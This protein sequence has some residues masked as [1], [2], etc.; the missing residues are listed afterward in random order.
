[1]PLL[2][3]RRRFQ[4]YSLSH[5]PKGVTHDEARLIRTRQRVED[6]RVAGVR[7]ALANGRVARRVRLTRGGRAA[8]W[9]GRRVGAGAYGSVYATVSRPEVMAALRGAMANRIE[10]GVPRAGVQVVIKV[11]E[12]TG[13]A[14]LQ[15][16]VRE[17]AVHHQLATAPCLTSRRFRKPVCVEGYVPRLYFAGMVRDDGSGLAGKNSAG[18]AYA[19]LR[20][21]RP[22][23]VTVM[24]RA[25]GRE[26]KGLLAGRRA[27]GARLYVGVER[28]VA[29]LWWF[30]VMHN[31][32]HKGN[33]MWDAATGAFSV[34]DFGFAA[35]IPAP[36]LTRVR[37]AIERG[38]R[39]GVRSLGEV[40]RDRSRSSVG[41]GLQAYANSLMHTRRG[42]KL[43]WFNPDGVALMR[44]YSRMP[45]SERARVP[46]LRRVAW[47]V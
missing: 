31:D 20:R 25:P 12:A 36:L 33:M 2:N 16:S 5:R 21:G 43:K 47:G 27:V 23:F 45:A 9:L 1:M 38:V 4:A 24:G 39:E 3:V 17:A 19:P 29:S 8:S 14:F 37:D 13:K 30:G 46:A 26:L 10:Y 6:V 32:L 11:A 41:T 35:A 22:T 15:D 18:R 7:R 34:I 42:S 28:A 44:M 40:W